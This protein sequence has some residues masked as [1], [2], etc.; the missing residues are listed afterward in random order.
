MK[1]WKLV[2]RSN[3]YQRRPPLECMCH[4]WQPSKNGL[5]LNLNLN[6]NLNFWRRDGCFWFMSGVESNRWWT[7]WISHW[8]SHCKVNA[9]QL[10]LH[11]SFA[12][13]WQSEDQLLEK[14]HPPTLGEQP[15]YVRAGK[16]M[17]LFTIVLAGMLFT[18]TQWNR[19]QM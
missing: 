13:H 19:E 15:W 7:Y 17:M 8:M 6:G 10:H 11:I 2:T 3:I 1:Q 16:L 9:S 14:K 4:P 18:N 5:N 12:F